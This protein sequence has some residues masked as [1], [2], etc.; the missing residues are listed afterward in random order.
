MTPKKR[1]R[2]APE[3]KG[4]RSMMRDGLL[5]DMMMYGDDKPYDVTKMLEDVNDPDG[6]DDKTKDDEPFDV[7]KM[8]EEVHDRN[9][10]DGEDE[11]TRDDDPSSL[12]YQACTRAPGYLV[13]SCT[14]F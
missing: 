13:I 6:E 1:K 3:R 14:F 8:L 4:L 11:K 12:V 9:D 5:R 7:T 10:P 2:E